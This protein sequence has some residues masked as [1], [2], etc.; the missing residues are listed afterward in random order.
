[1][2]KNVVQAADTPKAQQTVEEL[3]AAEGLGPTKEVM[4]FMA[5]QQTCGYAI[6]AKPS[7]NLYILLQVQCALPIGT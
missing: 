7:A 6:T 5:G 1:M 3:S 4:R 2:K